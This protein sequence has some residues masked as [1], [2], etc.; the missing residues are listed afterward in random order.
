MTGGFISFKYLR[1][2]TVYKQQDESWWEISIMQ[3]YK[4]NQKRRF[5]A[6]TYSLHR[7]TRFIYDK[8]TLLCKAT[9]SVRA[10]TAYKLHKPLFPFFIEAP[11]TLRQRNLKMQFS[12][13]TTTENL[14]ARQSPVILD[15]R[16]RKSG[17]ERSHDHP[18]VIV[19]EKLRYVFC[20]Q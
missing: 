15:L 5:L 4:P 2:L 18:Y 13:R 12:V 16:S 6:H 8:Q 11:F 17:A 19:F 10:D 1:A 3:R 7:L 20:P 14:K 9:N